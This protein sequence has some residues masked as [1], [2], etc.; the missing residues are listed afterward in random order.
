MIEML[1]LAI[2]AGAL[3]HPGAVDR[4]RRGF[5]LLH[6]FVRN[7]QV[8][9]LDYLMIGARETFDRLTI[10]RGNC[11]SRI[12]GDEPGRTPCKHGRI[13]AENNT[14]K[15]FQKSPTAIPGKMRVPRHADQPMN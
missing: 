14:A 11:G 4:L 5:E 2:G 3:A 13:H 1:K 9:I 8:L 10:K 12:A 7:D 15:T 6:R